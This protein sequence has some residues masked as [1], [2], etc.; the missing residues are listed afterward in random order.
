[1]AGSF[2]VPGEEK[3]MMTTSTSLNTGSV[4]SGGPLVT[5]SKGFDGNLAS[6][7]NLKGGEM[8]GGKGEF[9]SPVC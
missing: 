4:Q 8:P 2:V 6:T 3:P 5:P 1:M 7:G 9:V